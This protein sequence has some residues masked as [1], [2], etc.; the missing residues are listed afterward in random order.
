MAVEKHIDKEQV[1]IA[2][3]ETDLANKERDLEVT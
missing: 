1:K 2:S 3:M